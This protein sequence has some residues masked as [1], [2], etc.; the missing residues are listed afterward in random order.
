MYEYVCTDKR[1]DDRGIVDIA[2][3]RGF[4]VVLSNQRIRLYSVDVQECFPRNTIKKI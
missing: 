4:G 1:V 2:R 3:V